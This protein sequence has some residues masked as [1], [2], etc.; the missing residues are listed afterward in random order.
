MSVPYFDVPLNLPHAARL[1]HRMAYH[2]ERCCEHH[3]I[4]ALYRRTLFDHA[5]HLI[6][7]LEPYVECEDNP[8][9]EESA[10]VVD[11]AAGRARQLVDGIEQAGVGD[12]RLG[13]VLRNFFECLELGE[14]GARLSLRAGENPHSLLRPN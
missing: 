7:L 10:R 4:P 8:E 13:Q 9:A 1:T 12:D 5:E 6:R 2:L 3:D 14:E 11:E